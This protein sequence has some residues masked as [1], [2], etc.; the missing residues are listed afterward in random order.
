MTAPVS[1]TPGHFVG[2]SFEVACAVSPAGTW[3]L[4]IAPKGDMNTAAAVG[5]RLDRCP[6][7][8]A[9]TRIGDWLHNQ[10]VDAAQRCLRSCREATS[11]F[12]VD[13]AAMGFSTSMAEDRRFAREH[14][15]R[16]DAYWTQKTPAADEPPPSPSTP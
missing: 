13:A 8:Y 6:T 11:S 5:E 15:D 3:C 12:H 9:G 16:S 10:T 7:L 4:L 14:W 2:Y 1:W